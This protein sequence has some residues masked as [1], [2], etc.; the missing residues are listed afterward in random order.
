MDIHSIYYGVTECKILPKHGGSTVNGVDAKWRM[1]EDLWD[2]ISPLLPPYR[3]SPLGGRP[4]E[5]DR[6]AMDGIFYLLRTGCQWKALPREFGASSTVYDR[7]RQWE[8]AG[9]FRAL[10]RKGVSLCDKKGS[11]DWEWQS[12]DGCMTKA[13]LGGEKTGPNPTDRAK[14][15]TKRSIL[16]D[17][18]GLPLAIAIDGANRHDKKMLADTLS[19]VIVPRPRP[20]TNA[21]QHMCLDKGYDYPDIRALVKKLKYLDHIKARGEETEAKKHIPGY[22][23]RRWVVERTHS[24]MNRFRRLLI[25]WEKLADRYLALL[26]LACGYIACKVAGVFG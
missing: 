26:H 11:I 21:P 16:T 7:F 10:W 15:G 14:S 18:D 2:A 4:R 12:V 9:V 19:G 5:N 23:A 3:P 17:G 13:P 25:R 22:R 24:W 20:S 8:Q 1:P 6:A